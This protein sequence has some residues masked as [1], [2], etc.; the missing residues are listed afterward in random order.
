MNRPVERTRR[1]ANELQL[2]CR[3]AD[4]PAFESHVNLKIFRLS[5]RTDLSS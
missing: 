1:K 2:A 5:L 3:L 4:S